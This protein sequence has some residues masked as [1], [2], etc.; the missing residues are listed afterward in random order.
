MSYLCVSWGRENLHTNVTHTVPPL[1]ASIRNKR[2]G[3][4]KFNIS[5][6]KPV[7]TTCFLPY[8][9]HIPCQPLAMRLVGDTYATDFW[10]VFLLSGLARKDALYVAEAMAH[11]QAVAAP[12]QCWCVKSRKHLVLKG[13]EGGG[14]R[15]VPYY[16][17]KNA[18]FLVLAL[19][20]QFAT[21]EAPVAVRK[22]ACKSQWCINPEHYYF[23]TRSDVKLEDNKRKGGNLSHELIAEIRQLKAKDPRKWTAAALARHYNMRY[24]VIRRICL[25]ETFGGN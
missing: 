22:A 21:A 4:Q 15:L 25:G 12:G 1:A 8:A 5:K 18:R 20:N 23:G 13:F 9:A 17:G 2:E 3:I 24:H 10:S 16:K 6:F 19:I 14:N 7:D 11:F